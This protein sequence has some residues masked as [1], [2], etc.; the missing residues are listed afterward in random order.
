[1][2]VYCLCYSLLF[3]NLWMP[4]VFV[5][6]W[7]IRELYYVNSNPVTFRIYT[8]GMEKGREREKEKGFLKRL[9]TE[10]LERQH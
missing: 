9:L 2:C 5:N 7:G 8:F 6:V 1:M 10:H 3:N 4:F